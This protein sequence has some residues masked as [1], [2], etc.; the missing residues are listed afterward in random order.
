ML[1]TKEHDT[2]ITMIIHHQCSYVV[3]LVPPTVVHCS[4]TPG[5]YV[6]VHIEHTQALWVLIY[7]YNHLSIG[8][9]HYCMML[10]EFPSFFTCTGERSDPLTV[11]W[12]ARLWHTRQ[13][14]AIPWS[15]VHTMYIL[16]VHCTC[17]NYDDL[18]KYYIICIDYLCV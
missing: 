12:L 4:H 7:E 8:I 6:P 11:H 1:C 17:I 16:S 5:A 14:S 13:P 3:A 2:K 18:D 15:V 10:C 9:I